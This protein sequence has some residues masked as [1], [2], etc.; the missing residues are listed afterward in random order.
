MRTRS[1]PSPHFRNTIGYATI[2]RIIRNYALFGTV[3]VSSSD[4]V[5]YLHGGETR[6]DALLS[7]LEGLLFI[8]V[9]AVLLYVILETSVRDT[10]NE[11]DS[12]RE[13]L[14]DARLNGNDIVLLMNESGRI[15]EANDRAIA[16][17]GY[18]INALCRMMAADLIAKAEFADRWNFCLRSG[19]LRSE[20]V[21]R[22]ADGSTFPVE[23]SARRFNTG[24]PI[25]IHVV[26]RDITAR[27][28]SE[29]QLVNLKDTYAA[30]L[31]TNQCIARC[32]DWDLLFQQT[33]DIAVRHL[34][35]KLAWI[36]IV[37][38][39]SG[40]VVPFAQAGPASDYTEGLQVSVDRDSPFSKGV[41]GRA[42][43]SGHPVV[44]NDLLESDGI[45]PWAEKLMAHGIKSWAAY[46]ISQ[47]GQSAGALT[48]Y[49]DNPHFFTSDLSALLEEMA[50]DLSL[51]LDRMA[52]RS[53]QVELEAELERLKKA[54]EQSQVAV[55][56][57]DRTGAIQYVNPAFSATSG[58]SAQEVLGKNPRILN[59]G[60]T[61]LL[62]YAAM[63]QRL[64]QGESW[65]GELVNK[66]KDGS[67]YWEEAV[68]SPVKDADGVIT[69]FIG[70]QQDITARREAE[71]RA[72]F[73]A[74]HDSLTELPT[75]DL[76]KSRM[77][78][79]ILEAEKS[80]GRAA[81][82]FMD[83]DNLKRV[84]D[85]LGHGMGDRLL[86]SLVR[87]LETNMREGDLLARVG[88]DE[89]LLVVLNV[90]GSGV[91]EA[92][93]QRIHESL[94]TPLDLEGL[95]V[96]TTVSVGA[97][98]YPD[99]GR[100]FDELYR[101]ADL[102]MYCAKKEGRNAFRAYAKS[103]EADTHE[104]VATVNGLRRALEKKELLLY[105]QPQIHLDTGDVRAVEALLRWERPGHGLVLPG[106][107]I[108][109]AEESG[110]IIE[111]GNW[112][113]REVCRQAAEWRD[114]GMPG[115]RV[116]FNL[117]A[118]QLR[119]GGL[120]EV[121]AAAMRES[122]LEPEFLELELTES[123]LVND[124]ADATSYLRRLR[125]LGIG[126]ALDDFGTGYSNF[127]YLRRFDLDRLKID[128][129]FVRN[130]T[131]QNK[132][133]VAIVKS[134]VQLARN[135]GLE[136]IAEGVETEEALSLVR[137][138]GCDYVQGFLLAH[139]MPAT[140]V[141]AFIASR[142]GDLVNELVFASSKPLGLT[143]NSVQ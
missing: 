10:V 90:K 46:P 104:Y 100:N 58:Y 55:V 83:V 3:W 142:G 52:L 116:S 26:I 16:A 131:S 36:G 130:I 87:R 18:D 21:H 63:W 136:T 49:S 107:F 2:L 125:E 25:L 66:R 50:N 44:V 12:Y 84:N 53:K 108:N 54:V 105:Y 110:L 91:V 57:S 1:Q 135:F 126:I 13:R 56:I 31:Q 59:S 139:P 85:S 96:P 38:A 5:V 94:T 119:R 64:T 137:R 113:I 111:I 73:L 120:Q 81:L 20:S 41:A 86:Q 65:A 30:L 101:Q 47:G 124:I 22:R 89:F 140:A 99:D 78:D 43:L 42:L 48:L 92:I 51:A 15:L 138:A 34:H 71:E 133:D 93:A 128:Q 14:R 6:Q 24:G 11:R 141:P 123:T 33:C 67:L 118:L 4:V 40:I 122:Q 121:I 143:S 88:G 32:S 79:A 127:T 115:L 27:H 28:E 23:F 103:M 132:G 98:I 129:S 35:L 62:Q 102:A 82:L 80:G 9:S 117:S 68:I 97:A 37:D 114:N 7:F 29:R 60:K 112:V 61:P 45:Q 72:R 106:K 95:E 77:S 75:R 19:S 74:F 17:Y 109:V 70:V 76:A 8:A 69:H 134:I 39:S